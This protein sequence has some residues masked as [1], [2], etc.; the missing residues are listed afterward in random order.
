M[1]EMKVLGI[2]LDANNNNIPIVVLVDEKRKRVLPIWVGFFEAQSILLALE[3]IPV[4]R[5][6]SH[7]L[8]CD[9]INK[10][11][12]KVTYIYISTLKE[13]TYYA[14]INLKKGN[15]NLEI[16]SRPSDAIAVAL[17]ENVAIFVSE[18]IINMASKPKQPID[19]E[20]VKRFK[21]K[22]KDL[23]PRDFYE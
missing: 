11:E 2:A 7:D 13:N 16:D 10:L 23:S 21:E 19:E 1:I 20:E 17:R 3:H 15:Q 4:P 14:K 6:L 22:L 5:P 18:P 8:M 9:I 12:G